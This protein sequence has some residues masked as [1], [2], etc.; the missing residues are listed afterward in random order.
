MEPDNGVFAY[1]E[2]GSVAVSEVSSDVPKQILIASKNRFRRGYKMEPN[3]GV[4]AYAEVGS[5]A[6]SEV[7]S[8]FCRN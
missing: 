6:V 2:V 3:N 8:D 1:A 7:S 5:V 4:C